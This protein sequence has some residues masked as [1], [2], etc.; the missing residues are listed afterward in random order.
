MEHRLA[1]AAELQV[2]QVDMLTWV[3]T[4]ALWHR[5]LP[6]PD[7]LRPTKGQIWTSTSFRSHSCY[8]LYRLLSLPV[9]QQQRG[10][11]HGISGPDQQELSM[12][13]NPLSHHL[14]H[15]HHTQAVLR[16]LPLHCLSHCQFRTGCQRTW[17]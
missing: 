3:N 16:V 7:T 6:A 17:M 9:E 13:Q 11:C 5:L 14:V 2:L 8:Q 4:A 15:T 12:G 10:W 1:E